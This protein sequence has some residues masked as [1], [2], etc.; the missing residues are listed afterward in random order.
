MLPARA[1]LVCALTACGHSDQRAEDAPLP[2]ADGAAVDSPTLADAA[3]QDGSPQTWESIGLLA[4]HGTYRVERVSYRVGGLLVWGQICRPTADGAWPVLIFDHGG[5]DGLGAEW[6]GSLC[7]GA[8]NGLV[9][10]AS[11]YRGEDGSDG[12]VEVCLGEVD[13]VLTLASIVRRKPYADGAR[14]AVLGGSHGGCI[15]LR[16]IERGFDAVAAAD[17]FGV[18]D[19]AGAYAYWQAEKAAHP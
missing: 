12:S 17:L 4:D 1:L 13:D 18:T 15:T 10:A 5:F 9:I 8:Q 14:L 6:D 7:A 16:A 11:S 3:R 19:W 2:S